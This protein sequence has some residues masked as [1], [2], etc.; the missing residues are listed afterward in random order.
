M[1]TVITTMFAAATLSESA[2]ADEKPD[3][4][5]EPFMQYTGDQRRAYT[6]N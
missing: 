2:Q 6:Y 4:I 1:W 3:G 5:I